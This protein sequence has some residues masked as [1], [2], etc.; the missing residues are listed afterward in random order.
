VIS[1]HCGFDFVEHFHKDELLRLLPLI[2]RA[3]QADGILLL[4]TPNGERL[5]S[6]Q[7]IHADLTH[8]T[9]FSPDSLRQ[10]LALTG[11]DEIRF[12]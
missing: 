11:F 6:Q 2:N 4:Q 9:I 5:F 7:V 10:L 3:L 12:L 1:C 8:L